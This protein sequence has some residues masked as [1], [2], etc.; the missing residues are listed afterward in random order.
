MMLVPDYTTRFK[1]RYKLLTDYICYSGTQANVEVV[2][3]M[4]QSQADGNAQV[5]TIPPT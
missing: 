5:I 1:L 3:V 2:D 4:F